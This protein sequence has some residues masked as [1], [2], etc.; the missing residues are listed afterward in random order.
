MKH[1]KGNMLI[2]RYLDK[3]EF[4]DGCQPAWVERCLWCQTQSKL[5]VFLFNIAVNWGWCYCWHTW[6]VSAGP[7]FVRIPNTTHIP[8]WL[9]KWAKEA[10]RW[11]FPHI[12]RP[13]WDRMAEWKWKMC[14]AQY[15][16]PDGANKPVWFVK[17]G[18]LF[19]PPL[20]LYSIHKS[21]L[22]RGSNGRVVNIHK[23]MS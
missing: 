17:Q 3:R 16:A 15:R 11:T 23:F 1:Q 12:R 18:C 5:V 20:L 22:K 6:L 2:S 8:R 9:F 4:L 21:L 19:H 7:C 13:S 10:H 14:I